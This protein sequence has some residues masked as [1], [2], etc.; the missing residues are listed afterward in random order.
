[1]NLQIESWRAQIALLNAVKPI[2]KAY[3]GKTYSKRLDKAIEE[4]YN[5]RE[6]RDN[7]MYISH[8]YGDR[9]YICASCKRSLV[10]EKEHYN[11]HYQIN[12]AETHATLVTYTPEDSKLRRI[13][14]AETIKGI[15]ADIEK[16]HNEID[17]SLRAYANLTA[18]REKI[19]EINR[20]LHEASELVKGAPSEF[21]HL[22]KTEYCLKESRY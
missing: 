22:Y 18:Y 1:M 19:T 6:S 8:S 21:T 13:N 14:A 7:R 15:D 4:K 11:D 16:I 20:I 17:Q 9:L 12:D 2:I 3:D 10:I 5:T